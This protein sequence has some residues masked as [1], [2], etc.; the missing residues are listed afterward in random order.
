MTNA[1]AV[2]A[3]NVLLKTLQGHAAGHAD[4]LAKVTHHRQE[5][6]KAVFFLERLVAFSVIVSLVAVALAVS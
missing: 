1:E 4:F 3:I 5:L 6:T 2:E